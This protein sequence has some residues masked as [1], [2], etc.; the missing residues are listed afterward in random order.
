VDHAIPSVLQVPMKVNG[1]NTTEVSQSYLNNK[2]SIVLDVSITKDAMEV[3]TN[4]PGITSNLVVATKEKILT[5]TLHDKDAADS[6]ED[7]LSQLAL[8][9]TTP[10]KEVRAT[11]PTPL[12]M[13]DQCLLPLMPPHLP[14]VVTDLESTTAEAVLP[15]VSTTPSLLSDTEVKEVAITTWSRTRGEP[16][17]EPA[18]TSRWPETGATTAVLHPN[19]LTQLSEL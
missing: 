14:S 9:S 19:L 16:D 7:Q 17:G 2:L 12:P 1:R 15:T 13:S 5:A 4:G 3:G 18:D 8:D 10:N 6:T 11:W